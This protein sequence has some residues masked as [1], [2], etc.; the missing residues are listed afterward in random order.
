MVLQNA[1]ATRSV[2]LVDGALVGSQPGSRAPLAP[3]R[4]QPAPAALFPL[5]AVEAAT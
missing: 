4:Q 3:R 5:G 1:A 2:L